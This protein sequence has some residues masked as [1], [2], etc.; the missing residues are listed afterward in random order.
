MSIL[1]TENIS[2]ICSYSI[3][4]LHLVTLQ[5][6]KE[7]TVKVSFLL[8]NEGN[9]H[10]LI[11]PG[12]VAV[13]LVIDVLTEED[14]AEVLEIVDGDNWFDVIDIVAVDDALDVVDVSDEDGE[15]VDEA[16]ILAEENVV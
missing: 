9:M 8:L 15:D 5:K 1:D 10:V 16:V 14:L 4:C 6:D 2:T 12:V 11:S 3:L 13:V 7:N